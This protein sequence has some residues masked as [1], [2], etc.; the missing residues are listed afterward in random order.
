MKKF[1]ILIV[2][3]LGSSV[4]AM[5]KPEVMLEDRLIVAIRNNNLDEV[6]AA[7]EAGAPINEIEY[8]IGYRGIRPLASALSEKKYLIAEYLLSKGADN[9]LLNHFFFQAVTAADAEHVKWLLDHGAKDVNDAA[10]KEAK[11]IAASVGSARLKAPYTQIVKLLENAK[12]GPL[13]LAPKIKPAAAKPAPAQLQKLVVNEQE[14]YNA[15]ETGSIATIKRLLD[16]GLNPDY[17]FTQ[18]NY[19]DDT[20]LMVLLNIGKYDQ[21]LTQ[22]G[23]LLFAKGAKKATGMRFGLAKAVDKNNVELVRW[24]LNQGTKDYQNEIIDSVNFRLKNL[25]EPLEN[26]PKLTQIK[27][28]LEGTVGQPVRLTPMAKPI[29]RPA[30]K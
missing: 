25:S 11:D 27:Q 24:F 8:L 22:I 30:G 10:L 7:V 29:A 2:L 28:L 20:P 4:I 23:D 15:L 19:K 17:V 14:L 6:R 26:K 9:S 1:F 3:F 16:Q 21:S 12:K 5:Q 13:K 18:G